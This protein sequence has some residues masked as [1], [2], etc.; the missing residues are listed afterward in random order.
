[1]LIGSAPAISKVVQL[2]VGA[3]ETV[4]HVCS[5]VYKKRNKWYDFYLLI[6]YVKQ[7]REITATYEEKIMTKTSDASM[8][9]IAQ[10]LM[11]LNKKTSDTKFVQCHRFF[12]VVVFF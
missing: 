4:W 6:N 12:F 8:N 11:T 2:R 9:E 1:M 10:S 5:Y 3:S 7:G